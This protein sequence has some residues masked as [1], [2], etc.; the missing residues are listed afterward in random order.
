MNFWEALFE[1]I[2]TVI[3]LGILLTLDRFRKE[4]WGR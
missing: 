4:R 2:Q 1:G 3:L